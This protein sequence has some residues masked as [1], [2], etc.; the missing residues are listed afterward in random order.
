MTLS[1]EFILLL[2][3]VLSSSVGMPVIFF[4]ASRLPL[5]QLEF[6]YATHSNKMPH[7]SAEAKHHI[8]LEYAPGDATR[9]FAA[10]AR[11][12]GIEGGGQ[13]VGRWHARWNGTADSLKERERSGRPPAL[14]AEQ[15]DEYVRAP[16]RAANRAHRAIHYPDLLSSLRSATGADISLRTLQRHGEEELAVKQKRGIKRTANERQSNGG[17]EDACCALLVCAD[18]NLSLSLSL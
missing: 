9:S 13:T 12:H 11:R 16:I 8:L 17:V 18:F 2:L 7:L 14:S 15:V 10:L 1:S 5:L 4:S 6:T 3:V